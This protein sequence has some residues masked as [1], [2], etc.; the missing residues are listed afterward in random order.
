MS[1]K[2]DPDFLAAAERIGSRL[3]RD[4]I[5]FEG[6][7]N[8][9]G[10]SMEAVGGSWTVVER[11][12][13]PNLYSGTSGI[14][15]FLARLHAATDDPVHR[16]IASSAIAQSR[17]Q[18]GSLRENG[19]GV[20]SGLLG[21]AYAWLE[22]DAIFGDGMLSEAANDLLKEI[23]A[24]DVERAELDVVSG[25]AGAIPV[26]LDLS[27]HLGEPALRDFAQM[28]GER[29][30]K[31]AKTREN[32]MSWPT[33]QVPAIDHLTG[34][35][36]GTAGIAWALYELS[37]ETGFDSYRKAADA[38]IAYE[39]ACYSAEHGNWP[40]FRVLN[41]QPITPEAQ[42]GYGLAWCHGAPGIGLARVRSYE[43]TG[44]RSFLTEIDSAVATTVEGFSNPAYV[45]NYSLCHG[46]FGNAELLIYASEVLG[47]AELADKARALGIRALEERDNDEPWSCGTSPSSETPGLMLGLAG[48]GYYYLRLFDSQSNP[49]VLLPAPRPNGRS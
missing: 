45:T 14:A 40:D 23:L 4:A 47:A 27:R 41:G 6:R 10:A 21:I 31:T 19:I 5:H 43:L 30:L 3:C 28:L 38:G 48:I 35:S 9:I 22:I 7:C 42:P 39:R 32:G 12:F 33:V 1:P 49:S 29:L 18:V 24:S 25:C 37:L 13:G 8:W 2:G 44:D 36:H 34:F 15:L 11:S 17:S 26:L 16:S 20:Y 46:A